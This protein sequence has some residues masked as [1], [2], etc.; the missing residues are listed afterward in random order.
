M[1]FSIVPYFVLRCFIQFAHVCCFESALFFVSL[2]WLITCWYV[3]SA[4]AFQYFSSERPNRE[5][6]LLEKTLKYYP[7]WFLVIRSSSSVFSWTFLSISLIFSSIAFT[8]LSIGIFSGITSGWR[9]GSSLCSVS[10]SALTSISTFEIRLLP[11]S[12]LKS[13]Y[14][15]CIY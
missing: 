13:I 10:W 3:V 12:I 8:R 14:R 7:F 9:K 11:T 4:S 15:R 6:K 1:N 2:T 5:M